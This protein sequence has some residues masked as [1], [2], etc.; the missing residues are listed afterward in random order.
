MTSVQLHPLVLL[1]I[2]DQLTRHLS[3]DGKFSSNQ[4]GTFTSHAF[5]YFWKCHIV[6][7]ALLGLQNGRAIEIITSYPLLLDA[8]K[9]SLDRKFFESEQ[10]LIKQVFP[11]Y[12]FLG[13]YSVGQQPVKQDI[14]LHKQVH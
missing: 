11:N 1:N 14:T 8:S 12:E 5:K 7:G 10:E 6:I 13:W 2:S 3:D 9:L 4:P